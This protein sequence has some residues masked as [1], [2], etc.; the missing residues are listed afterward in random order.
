MREA[1]FEGKSE[2]EAL[3]KA[4][5][6][7]GVNI[8]E[9]SYEVLEVETG[10]FGLFGKSVKIRV[11]VADEPAPI[12]LRKGIEPLPGGEDRPS[13][14]FERERVRGDDR[15]VEAPK[16]PREPAPVK[17]PEA[18]DALR[19]ILDRMEV[20]AELS[21]TENDEQVLINIRSEDRESVIGRDG[22]VLAALQFIVNKMV[23]RFPES[24]KL[25]VLDAEGFRDRR[26]E[27]LSEMA[28]RLG[29]KAIETGKVIRLSPMTAQDRRLVHLALKGRPGLTTRSDGQGAFRC[30][31]VIPDGVR[32]R[33][34][35]GRRDREDGSRGPDPRR[36]RGPGRTA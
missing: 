16:A 23:N 9:M 14:I 22:E 5:D 15:P 25:V 35:A 6:E 8:S 2:E 20:Q 31:L 33:P 26:E 11:R 21:M 24:R 7:L 4:S 10:L 30:L 13:R 28:R 29:D 19:G 36:D 18:V 3:L 12:V 34:S 32:E 1:I 17:G 27:E